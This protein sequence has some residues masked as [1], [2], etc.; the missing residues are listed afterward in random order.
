MLV[1]RRGGGGVSGNGEPIISD[2][3]P[4]ADGLCSWVDSATGATWF[5]SNRDGWV[6][7]PYT[8]PNYSGHGSF[9]VA[10]DSIDGAKIIMQFSAPSGGSVVVATQADNAYDDTPVLYSADDGATWTTVYVSPARVFPLSRF[11]N[12]NVIF[13]S[14]ESAAY[15]FWSSDLFASV[16]KWS[17]NIGV[18]GN[19]LVA[20]ELL[21]GGAALVGLNEDGL[22]YFPSYTNRTERTQ[23]VNDGYFCSIRY[24]PELSRCFALRHPLDGNGAI[25]VV[26]DDGTDCRSVLGVPNGEP[27]MSFHYSPTH[28]V[29]IAGFETDSPDNQLKVLRSL[30]HGETWAPVLFGA[31]KGVYDFCEPSPGI[32]LAATGTPGTVGGAKIYM[33]SDGG[34]MWDLIATLDPETETCVRSIHAFDSGVVVA[35]GYSIGRIYRNTY[36]KK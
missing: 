29:V 26:N 24:I 7:V 25:Y 9:E 20:A 6:R 30:D 8:D 13:C 27:I 3:Q 17:E 22:Y 36:W 19:T 33:S 15:L 28:D 31:G 16:D 21:P 35:G 11:D 18:Y 12:G 1:R 5:H 10:T 14:V 23:F 32:I 4:D 34:L 2:I